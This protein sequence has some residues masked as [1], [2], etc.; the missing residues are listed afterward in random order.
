MN[1]ASRVSPARHMYKSE[2][3][4]NKKTKMMASKMIHKQPT[5]TEENQTNNT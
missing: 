2:S 1:E 3:N 5:T 4:L